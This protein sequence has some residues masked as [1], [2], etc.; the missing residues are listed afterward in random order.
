VFLEVGSIVKKN[1]QKL[2]EITVFGYIF[3]YIN[4]S[5][6]FTDWQNWTFF[7]NVLWTEVTILPVLGMFIFRLQG[8]SENVLL[9]PPLGFHGIQYMTFNSIGLSACG[10]QWLWNTLQKDIRPDSGILNKYTITTTT[11]QVLLRL[12]TQ[13]FLL[14]TTCIDTQ[15]IQFKE[16]FLPASEVSTR[17]VN[18]CFG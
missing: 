6:G 14:R 12:F 17:W 8:G 18:L 5:S 15:Q 2:K 13:E 3:F 1:I 7:F 16:H 9:W 10:V 4:G 11:T